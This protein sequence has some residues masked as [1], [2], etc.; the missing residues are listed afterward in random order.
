MYKRVIFGAVA[1]ERVAALK[2]LSA[3]ESLVLGL[4]AVAVLAM[5][6][7]PDPFAEVLHASVNDL[8]A[9]ATQSKLPSP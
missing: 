9:Q 8:L 5:G 2:D 6:I 4:L 1:N 7:Y 3:R